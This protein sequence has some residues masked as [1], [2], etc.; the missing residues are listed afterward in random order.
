MQVQNVS[1]KPISN[2]ANNSKKH[3]YV[4]H[5]RNDTKVKVAALAG[6]GIGIALTIGSLL[7]KLKKGGNPAKF[8][9]L[10]L[11]E[12]E[13][14]KLAAGS[15]LGG[16][17]GGLLAD[18]KENAKPK[19]REAMQQFFGNIATPIGLLALSKKGLE[20]LVEK[21]GFEMPII[22]MSAENIVKKPKLTKL[23]TKLNSVIKESPKIAVT[24][25]SLVGGLAIGNKIMNKVTDKIFHEKQKRDV[26]ASDYSAHVDDLCLASAFI[27]ENPT[28]NKVMAKILPASYLIA[29]FETG[30]KKSR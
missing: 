28:F 18:K 10:K 11:E 14:L 29:G 15:I 6:S 21:T 17:T 13:A 26:K 7:Y 3:E 19:V 9:D 23:V 25:A 22:E 2:K 20:K 4:S 5:D 27:S 12:A 24:I 30:T 1:N 16:L 8:A